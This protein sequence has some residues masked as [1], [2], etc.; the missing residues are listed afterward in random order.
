M[1]VVPM[2]GFKLT[3]VRAVE[4]SDMIPPAYMGGKTYKNTLK[5]GIGA[6][7]PPLLNDSIHRPHTMKVL[8][9]KQNHESHRV[10]RRPALSN[11]GGM[12][13]STGYAR[14]QKKRSCIHRSTTHHR[15]NYGKCIFILWWV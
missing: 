12:F 2:N 8:G 3:S 15:K 4:P 6:D 13:P 1:S 9:C 10:L 7:A 11:T 5:I 14:G